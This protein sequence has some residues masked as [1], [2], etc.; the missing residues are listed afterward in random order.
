MALGGYI[1]IGVI[2][3]VAGTAVLENVLPLGSLGR[4]S[5]GGTLPLLSVTVGVEVAAGTAL[6][7]AEFL[8]QLVRLSK[9]RQLR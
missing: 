5:A 7:V 1:V 2:G 6:V 3:V 8:E 4:L 9:R